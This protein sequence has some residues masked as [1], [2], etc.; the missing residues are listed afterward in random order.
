MLFRSRQAPIG[1]DGRY[2]IKTLVGDNY[3][4]IDCKELRLPRNRAIAD[5]ERA[6]IVSSGENTIDLKVPPE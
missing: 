5:T 2:T 4:Q 3:V 1:K 6:V